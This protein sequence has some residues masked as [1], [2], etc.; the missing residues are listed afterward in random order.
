MNTRKINKLKP[1]DA[2]LEAGALCIGVLADDG[3]GW[4]RI[5]AVA[6]ETFE[7]MLSAAAKDAEGSGDRA[8]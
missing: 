4:E 7:A 1:T 6:G 5:K 8:P 3:Y 2:M